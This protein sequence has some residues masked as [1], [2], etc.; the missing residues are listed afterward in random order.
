M[1]VLALNHYVSDWIYIN[2]A[3]LSVYGSS[4]K[5]VFGTKTL[6]LPTKDSGWL[7]ASRTDLC[8]Y[9]DNYSQQNPDSAA[10]G[11]V[12]TRPLPVKASSKHCCLLK[13]LCQ[14]SPLP[15]PLVLTPRPNPPT[16]CWAVPGLSSCTDQDAK[17]PTF[18]DT[19]LAW[20][21]VAKSADLLAAKKDFLIS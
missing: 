9:H 10:W 8:N 17:P 5:Y 15:T 2:M 16:H 1:D 12:R 6:T 11:N 3:A 13:R 4:A 19:G 7:S 20:I 21:R 18:L 14:N